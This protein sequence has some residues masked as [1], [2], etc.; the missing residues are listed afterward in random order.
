M[1]ENL[2][3]SRRIIQ[4]SDDEQ[5]VASSSGSVAS[6]TRSS[7]R[8]TRSSSNATDV[9]ANTPTR[10]TRSSS[11]ASAASTATPTRRTRSSSNVSNAS[12][13]T[14]TRRGGGARSK[15]GKEKL[16]VIPEVIETEGASGVLS[17][18]KKKRTRHCSEDATSVE[19]NQDDKLLDSVEESN[20]ASPSQMKSSEKKKRKKKS[21]AESPGVKQSTSSDK[22]QASTPNKKQKKKDEKKAKVTPHKKQQSS[23][24]ELASAS[25]QSPS[26]AKLSQ[27]ST[28]TKLTMDVNVHRLRFLKLNPKSI[29]AMSATPAVAHDN[30][31][32]RSPQRL[33]VSR[34]GGSVELLSP[35]DRWVSVGDIPGVRGREV[36]ALVWVCGNN[37]ED[38]TGD[39]MNLGDDYNS[40]LTR[41]ADEQRRLFGCSRDGT[42]FELDFAKKRHTSVMG[43]GG[44]GVFCLASLCS[45][46]CCSSGGSSCGGYFAAGCEDG[47]VRV[48][49]ASSGIVRGGFPQLVSTLPSAG[50]AILSIAWVAGQ[51]SNH[52]GG[53]GG[54]VIF[55][56]VA[57]GTIRRYDCN[58]SRVVGTISTGSVLVSSSMGS[59]SISYRWNSSLRMTVENR[60]LQEATKVWALAALSDGTVISGDSLGHV[61]IWDGMSGT[62]TQTFDHNEIGADVLC[63]A[64]SDD[65]NKIFAGGVDPR[66]QCIQRQCLPPSNNSNHEPSPVRKWINAQANRKH[67]HDVKA[68]AICHKATAQRSTPNELLVSGG[69]DTRIC[70][71]SAEDFR[72]SRPKIWYNWPSVS[73][74]SISRRQRLLAVTR[75]DRIDL[76]RLDASTRNT[77]NTKL[78]S[79]EPRDETKCFVK[80]L[81]IKSSFNIVCSIISDDGAFL[82]ASDASS[83]YLFSLHVEA[84]NGIIEDVRPTK[85]NLSGECRQPCTALRFDSFGRLV[86]ATADG[87]ISILRIS[88]EV[89]KG[90]SFSVSLDHTFKEH[91]S[92][93][94]A[95]SHHFPVSCLDVSIDGKWLAAGRFASG[96]GAVHVFT[97]PTL[98]GGR[99]QHWWSVPDTME[100]PTTSIKFLGRGGS[101][102][103]LCVG[104]SNNAFHIFNLETRSLSQWNTDMGFPLVKSLPRELTSRSEPVTRIVCNPSSP[105]KL[106]LGAHGFFCHVDLHQPVPDRANMFPPDSLRAKRIQIPNSE[107]TSM[108]SLR[109][110]EKKNANLGTNSNFTVCLRYDCILFQEFVEDNEMVIVE[111]PWMS[112]LEDLPDALSRR[113]YGT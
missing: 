60:G 22:S 64:V 56:G 26:R 89:G 72:S 19:T 45:R 105:Q 80:S 7:T 34:E 81:H 97:L 12:T 77:S 40:R 37:G 24:H 11:N 70:M 1:V 33:A 59:T 13:P 102:S 53:M 58:A 84:D 78:R 112:I 52:D 49:R 17:E 110:Q 55:A 61:Q 86:C 68:L 66:V 98:Q 63:L 109:H 111:Q 71:Y 21:K 88:Q 74:V 20:H 35:Q 62:M 50:N 16:D 23:K 8:R 76:Y 65:E 103:A 107:E 27:T 4:R 104:Y 39:M 28:G 31:S 2:R 87:P 36:D 94:S 43:S 46:K 75:D 100:V 67:T 10:R 18:S 69:V 14:S 106:I 38:S 73:P 108:H 3:R 83:L 25:K 32:P 6:A 79:S 48:Y 99:H 90:V 9:G 44:G 85:I 93:L 54:S 5:S 15:G 101:E 95:S 91:T 47:S 29:L 96:K 42:I 57:D 82:A 51:N 113:V 41:N 30:K 92:G